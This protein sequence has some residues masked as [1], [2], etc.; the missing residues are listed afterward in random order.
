MSSGSDLPSEIM[1][2]VQL[3]QDLRKKSYLSRAERESVNRAKLR[4]A[5]W[6]CK[7]ESIVASRENLSYVLGPD[8]AE[9]MGAY[10]KYL[11]RDQARAEEA[12]ARRA[13]AAK[14]KPGDGKQFWGNA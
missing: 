3:L 12:K 6:A 11:E 8:A 13:K 9:I 10:D 1:D 14:K 7:S 5:Y 4:I 2:A